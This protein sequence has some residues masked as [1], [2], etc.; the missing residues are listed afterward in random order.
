MKDLVS[1]RHYCVR[2]LHSGMVACEGFQFIS[3]RESSPFSR[4]TECIATRES[5]YKLRDI[6]LI[7]YTRPSMSAKYSIT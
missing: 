6:R 2:G 3:S 1:N 7:R 5:V 4:L